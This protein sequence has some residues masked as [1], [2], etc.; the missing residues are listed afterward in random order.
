MTQL[1]KTSA[2]TRI[3][4][5]ERKGRKVLGTFPSVLFHI[6]THF[7]KGREAKELTIDFDTAEAARSLRFRWYDFKK[8]LRAQAPDRCAV[9]DTVQC[10][11]RGATLIFSH[12]DL[13]EW[14]LQAEQQVL[15]QIGGMGASAWEESNNAPD[16]SAE[17]IFAAFAEAPGTARIPAPPGTTGITAAP[18]APEADSVEALMMR[19]MGIVK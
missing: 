8:A 4:E 7:E 6:L 12:R 3:R 5:T 9:A 11:L 18:L 16:T 13:A 2:N 10:L 17:D 1:S 19:E 15:A 14:N